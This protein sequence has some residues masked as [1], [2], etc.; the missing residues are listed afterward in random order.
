MI[1]DPTRPASRRSR[2]LAAAILALATLAA[3]CESTVSYG[4]GARHIPRGQR[5]RFRD[6]LD[7]TTFQRGNV[8]THTTE[9]DGDHPPEA[10]AAWYRDHGYNFLVITD[11]NKFTD[12]RRYRGMES[13]GFVM[14]PGEEVTLRMGGGAHVHINALCTRRRIGGKRF[15]E[16]EEAL[17]WGVQRT[18]EAG[19]VALVSHPNF[20]WSFGAESLPAASGARMLEIWSG[21]PAVHPEGDWRHPSV[22]SMWDTALSQGMDLAATAVDDMHN[23]AAETDPRHSGPGRGWIDVFARQASQGEI[24]NALANGWFV[25]SNGVRLSRLTVQGDALS[26][27]PMA[28]GGVVEFIG[29]GGQVLARHGVDPYGQRPN[30]YRLRGG[31]DYVRARVTAPSGARAWT[32]AYRVVY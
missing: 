6:Q 4:P 11:H 21:H 25:A 29:R 14:I 1:S 19:G 20:Y 15:A 24:C 26:V 9:S 22:E 27:L 10:V 30:V 5:G 16:V 31:E 23:L 3:G 17:R 7:V 13:S 28:P 8:H 2:V 12:P 18:I 32:Q